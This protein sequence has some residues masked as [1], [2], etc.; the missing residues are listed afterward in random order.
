MLAAGSGTPLYSVPSHAIEIL[1]VDPIFSRGYES[2]SQEPDKWGAHVGIK[3][4]VESTTRST[5]VEVS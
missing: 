1:D 4:I 5:E 2:A 3:D